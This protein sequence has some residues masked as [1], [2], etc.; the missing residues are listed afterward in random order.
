[1]T[2]VLLGLAVALCWGLADFAA[3][4][5]GRALGPAGSL[6]GVM[7]SG[8]AAL[9][10]WLGL[11]TGTVP[12]PL[13]LSVPIVLTAVAVVAAG[14]AFYGALS[15]GPVSLVVPLAGTY[16]AVTLLVAVVIDGIRP[17]LPAVAAM[18]AV[19][20]GVWVVA[21]TAPAADDGGGGRP[22]V[23]LALLASLLFA[24]S[25]RL[26]REAAL[27]EGEAAVLWHARWLGAV[28]LLAVP[29]ARRLRT[30]QAV[31]WLPVLVA[32]G[33]LDTLGILLIMANR[34]DMAATA[35]TVVSSTFGLVTILLALVF[36]GE[37]VALRQ[38]AG[39]AM[40]FGG[41]AALAAL[42][43]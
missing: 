11:T 12:G 32:Q 15:R 38:W 36:L 21:R 3:R 43:N 22:A 9:A 40:V 42:A 28:I 7:I 39:M 2:G 5:T 27:L 37:R 33:I 16:P 35:A 20:A 8:A 24:A 30:A 19:M 14:L 13:E 17:D 23:L 1:M 26:G 29:G 4:F 41:I 34:D 10:L 31:R 18:V 25:F 6:H